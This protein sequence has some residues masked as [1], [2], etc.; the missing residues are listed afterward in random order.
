[1]PVIVGAAQ[2]ADQ[3]CLGLHGVQ[4]GAEIRQ[5][6]LGIHSVQLRGDAGAAYAI[7]L[8]DG[9]GLLPQNMPI[10]RLFSRCADPGCDAVP[11]KQTDLSVQFHMVRRLF[12]ISVVL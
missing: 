2:H 11:E 10:G 7:P 3:I 1:M 5:I 8:D 9:A 12:S 4:P 6:N